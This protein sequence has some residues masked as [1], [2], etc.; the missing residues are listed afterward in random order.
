[1]GKNHASGLKALCAF[2]LLQAVILM[3]SMA[4]PLGDRLA[5]GAGTR[6]IFARAWLSLELFLALALGLFFFIACRPAVRWACA[7]ILSICCLLEIYEVAILRGFARPPI[8]YNDFLLL[9]DGLNLAFDLLP[10]GAITT[11]LSLALG[12]IF[13]TALNAW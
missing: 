9:W 11:I 10:G 13:L 12:G 3:P 8:L 6:E 2:T 1:M 7:S 4:L 5:V